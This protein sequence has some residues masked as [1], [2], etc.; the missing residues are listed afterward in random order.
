[1][2]RSL[3]PFLVAGLLLIGLAMLPA[4]GLPYGQFDWVAFSQG[5]GGVE[6]LALDRPAVASSYL[7]GSPPSYAVDGDLDTAWESFSYDQEWLYVVLDKPQWVNQV[8]VNW[9]EE[10]YALRYRISVLTGSGG[11]R[12]WQPVHDELDA[13][14]GVD[15]VNFGAVYGDAVAISMYG[16]PSGISRFSVREFEVYYL[17]TTPQES[18]N[19]A[20][21]RIAHATSYLSGYGPVHVTDQD[22]STGWRPNFFYDP[23]A[24]S[25]YIDLEDMYDVTQV[26]LYWGEEYPSQYGLYAW[27][28][29]WYRWYGYWAWWPVHTGDTIGD[30]DTATFGP[31]NTRYIRLV[32]Y[33]Y[34]GEGVDLREF[35]IYG[36]AGPPPE[37]GDPASARYLTP[38]MT[39]DAIQDA[40]HDLVPPGWKDSPAWHQVPL[41]EGI[42]AP[43]TLPMKSLPSIKN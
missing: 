4:V 12:Y 15:F 13:N 5:Y 29:V 6:N 40:L 9:G 31:I 1:M 43:E 22:L 24:P 42:P 8:V 41:K 25:I 3:S 23:Y 30:H 19:L 17:P 10:N 27:T 37:D 16:R 2:E 33:R 18:I 34:A 36:D 20:A 7:A 35:E 28:F 39:T 32:A 38:E 21:G 14:G 11:G 26:D